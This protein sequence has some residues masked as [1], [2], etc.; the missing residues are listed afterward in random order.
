MRIN[1][2]NER[3]FGKDYDCERNGRYSMEILKAIAQQKRFSPWFSAILKTTK[4][5][6]VLKKKDDEGDRKVKE[7]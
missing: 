2:K 4:I 1:L 3:S 6:P 5:I 7:W